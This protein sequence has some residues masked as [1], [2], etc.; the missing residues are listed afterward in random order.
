MEM[1][2]EREKGRTRGGGLAGIENGEEMGFC[3]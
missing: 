2:W 3:I 1:R